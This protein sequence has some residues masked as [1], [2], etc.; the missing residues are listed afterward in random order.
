MSFDDM[1]IYLL[2][3]HSLS[4]EKKNSS[5]FL[6]ENITCPPP[7]ASPIEVDM[8][9]ETT[10]IDKSSANQPVDQAPPP[11]PVLSP[12]VKR[13]L[14]VIQ[15]VIRVETRWA[16]KDF[17]ALK[18]STAQLYLRLTPIL[19]CFNNEHTKILEW[20]TDQVA[21]SATLDSSQ[22]SK[23]LSMK[24]V[25]NNQQ[26][27]FFF[28]FRVKATG[29]QFTQ[30]ARSKV[31]QTAKQ[32]EHITFD[33]S[34]IPLNQG[35]IVNIGDILLK[36]ATITQR[37]N[38]LHY[39]RSEVLPSNTPIFDIKIRH[40]DPS[41]QRYPILT[42]RCGRL[43]STLLS[44]ILITLLC[45]DGN[46]TEIFISRLA[47]GANNTTRREHEKIYA[48][49]RDYV[50]SLSRVQFTDPRLLDIAVSEHLESGEQ[51]SRTPRQWA[52]SLKAL[53]GWPMK[54]ILRMVLPMVKLFSYFLW[55]IILMY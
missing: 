17:T 30:T 41:G 37:G 6:P 36:D 40:K 55:N 39:L 2:Q 34:S 21:A 44:Q 51:F 29:A 35:D 33:P 4:K 14:P 27:C 48:V 38:N 5:L 1:D 7:D 45:G 22:L 3:L 28:S 15:H 13:P 12:M 31:L 43:V 42:I 47:L 53:D 32:G 50:Q 46:S 26:Q 16:P 19:S 49:H 11:S 24:V 20:Q 10:P 23:Y 54:W 18:H 25:A 52:K 8:E 9:T